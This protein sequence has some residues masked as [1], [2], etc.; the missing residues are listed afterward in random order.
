MRCT[1]CVCC[2][3]RPQQKYRCSSK[4][5]CLPR[6]AKHK[7]RQKYDKKEECMN[8]ILIIIITLSSLCFLNYSRHLRSRQTAAFQLLQRTVQQQQQEQEEQQQQ[9]QQ[10]QQQQQQEE[11]GPPISQKKIEARSYFYVVLCV[12]GGVGSKALRG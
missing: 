1:R 11:E 7:D 4:C 2:L 6:V 9:Q 10:E 3:R 5:L 8:L 12:C